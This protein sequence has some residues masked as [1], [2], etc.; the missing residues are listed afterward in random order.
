[1]N[2]LDP[3]LIQRTWPTNEQPTARLLALGPLAL[4]FIAA[5]EPEVE[6]C[7]DLHDGI[8]FRTEQHDGGEAHAN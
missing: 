1:M 4:C 6:P 7:R 5:K 8:S 2:V 3:D